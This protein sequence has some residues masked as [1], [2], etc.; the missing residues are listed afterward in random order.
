[1]CA[2]RRPSF[3]GWTV[4][5]WAPARRLTWIYSSPIYLW[6]C[7]LDRNVPCMVLDEATLPYECAACVFV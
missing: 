6:L 7:A 2:L 4:C 1:M 5:G 3:V